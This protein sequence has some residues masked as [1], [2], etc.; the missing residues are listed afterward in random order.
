MESMSRAAH[1]AQLRKPT[2]KKFGPIK[3]DDS[4]ADKGNLSTVYWKYKLF[5]KLVLFYCKSSSVSALIYRLY[6][7]ASLVIN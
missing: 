2:G 7:G 4:I 3:I 5:P 6:F 1:A